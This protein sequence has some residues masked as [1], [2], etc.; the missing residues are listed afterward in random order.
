[1]GRGSECRRSA[2]R[3]LRSQAHRLAQAGAGHD[4]QRV[5]AFYRGLPAKRIGAGVAFTDADG[6][7]L[8]VRP[9]YKEYWEIPGGLAEEGESPHEAATREVVEEI[10]FDRPAGRLLCVN[11]VPPRDPKTD[12]L[13]FL[14]D[15]GVLDSTDVAAIVLPPEELSEYRFVDPGDLKHYFP[16]RIA[17]RLVAGL[18]ARN[19]GSPRYVVNGRPLDDS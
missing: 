9:T 12:G 1:M 17:R 8:V 16:K 2:H 18:A 5:R 4:A 7:V 13:M 10:G 11:W 19:Q 14:F 6:R 15:G 3:R